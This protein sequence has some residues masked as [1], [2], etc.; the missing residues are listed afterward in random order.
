MADKRQAMGKKK[1]TKGRKDGSRRP[2]REEVPKPEIIWKPV[3]ELGKKVNSTEITDIEE[4]FNKGYNVLEPEIVNKLVPNLEEELLLIGQAKGKFGG[5][6]RRIFRQTQKK[7]REGNKIQF[8]TTALVGNKNGYVGV[9]SGKSKETVPARD[10]SKR[11][12]RLKLMRI[13]RGCGSWECNCRE[14]HSIPFAVEGGT[15]SSRII[16]MPAPKGKGLCIEKECAKILEMAGIKDIWSKTKGQT[17]TKLNLV[18]ALLDALQKLNHIKVKP[19]DIAR[20]G[21]IEGKLKG[22][23]VE[24]A[25]PEEKILTP[26][27]ILKE[28]EEETAPKVQKEE[29]KVPVL[30]NKEE[31]GVMIAPEE[32]KKEE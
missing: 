16:I 4:V 8:M 10:K 31:A 26:E 28:S 1:F 3:T 24:V 23:D 17:K 25:E 11:K 7:T 18:S 19:E 27:E 6:Q 30:E 12:A 13:R 9:A 5:G 21:I 20:L 2:R 14:P 29:S 32:E 22:E 15:G